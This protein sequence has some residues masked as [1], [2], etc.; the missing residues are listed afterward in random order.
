MK[1]KFSDQQVRTGFLLS[2]F[3][4]ELMPMVNHIL[5]KIIFNSNLTRMRAFKLAELIVVCDIVQL[6][7]EACPHNLFDRTRVH[8]YGINN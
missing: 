7:K 3:A 2:N 4:V 8:Q 5:V 1:E 6:I